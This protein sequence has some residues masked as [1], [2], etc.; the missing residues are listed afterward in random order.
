MSADLDALLEKAKGLMAVESW[1]LAD[2]LTLRALLPLLADHL[3]AQAKALK[4]A[5]EERNVEKKRADIYGDVVAEWRPIVERAESAERARDEA[6]ARLAKVERPARQWTDELIEAITG[7]PAD[8]VALSLSEVSALA[9]M[10]R[11]AFV[12]DG[13][14]DE[15][16]AR[17]ALAKPTEAA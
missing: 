15:S 7:H 12:P 2:R 10:H 3:A 6:Q 4:E 8:Q 1:D 17:A 9:V 16:V 13:N 11:A 14:D 5:L